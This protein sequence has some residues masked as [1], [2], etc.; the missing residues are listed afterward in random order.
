MA[1]RCWRLPVPQPPWQG[2]VDCLQTCSLWSAEAQRNAEMHFRSDLVAA[3]G[4]Q[5][6]RFN[7]EASRPAQM[8]RDRKQGARRGGVI[9]KGGGR[10]ASDRLDQYS[11]VSLAGNCG[12]YGGQ[13]RACLVIGPPEPVLWTNLPLFMRTGHASAMTSLLP[14]NRRWGGL[15]IL[16][17]RRRSVFPAASSTNERMPSM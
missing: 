2:M 1:R 10:E 16:A 11:Y 7:D 14:V 6:V 8:G 9:P 17:S 5:L 13:E 4:I 12:N 15:R 3:K